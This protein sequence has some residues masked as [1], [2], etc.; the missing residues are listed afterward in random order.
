MKNQKFCQTN[1]SYKVLVQRQES[2]HFK[3]FLTIQDP[4]NLSALKKIPNLN[5]LAL[6]IRSKTGDQ[7]LYE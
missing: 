3:R 4:S 6:Q 5:R 7:S 1:G 2:I